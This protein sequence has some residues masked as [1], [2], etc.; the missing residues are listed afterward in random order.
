[1]AGPL[2]LNSDG[3]LS[4]TTIASITSDGETSIDQMV[5]DTE[6]SAKEV[7]ISS[8]QNVQTT[9]KLVVGVKLVGIGVAR[10][11]TVNIKYVESLT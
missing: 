7:T 6:L 5:R 9:N 2:V 4:D 10:N 8:T 3:T 11:I 1:L